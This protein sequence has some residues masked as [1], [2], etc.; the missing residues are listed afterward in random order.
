MRIGLIDGNNFYVSCE[1]VFDPSL[2]G[3]PV[4]VLS[5]N[6][7]C[8]IA[9]SQE[10]KDLGISMGQPI[11]QVP[12][13]VRRQLHVRSANFA[14]YGD[15]SARVVDILRELFPV[16]SI[17][18]IDESFLETTGLADSL[19]TAREARRR[20]LQW[21]GIPTAVGIGVTRTL[22]KAANKLAKKDPGGVVVA[23]AAAL[24]RLPIEDVW[25]VGRQWA[26]RLQA[27]GVVTAGDLASLPASSVRA[28][29]GVVLARTHQE[30]NG[31]ICAELE[32]EEPERQQLIM[33]RSF[34]RDVTDAAQLHEAA[35]TFAVRC[36]ER[37]RGRGL[38]AGS[39]WVWLEGN[40]HRGQPHRASTTLPF[41][42]PTDDSRQ[43]LRFTRAL[44]EHL[45]RDGLAYKRV[46]VGLLDLG[47][48]AHRQQDLFAQPSAK[49]EAL[50]GVMDRINQRFGR[51]AAG[52]GA[53]GWRERPAWGMRQRTQS[54][55]YTTRWDQVLR[56]GWVG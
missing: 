4:V 43:L 52:F 18:S 55:A 54:P 23:D 25:G 48:S 27:E 2:R 38:V 31:R 39:I 6:D 10:A 32:I 8:A 11:H 40:R 51:N 44:V 12:R 14:L 33:A 22:A 15:L 36:G 46:G 41:P 42:I 47:A 28:R 53:T 3:V 34:G 45:R 13:E 16:V 29:Y 19:A 56:V 26:A 21:V 49:G 5:N 1:R 7:G 9:R 30:L 20:I 35:A 37:L 50:M 17:Y 24:Q